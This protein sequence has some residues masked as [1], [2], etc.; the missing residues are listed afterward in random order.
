MGTVRG[1]G[2]QPRRQWCL[3]GVQR[4]SRT[5][6]LHPRTQIISR[7]GRKPLLA[8]AGDQG[9]RGGGEKSSSLWTREPS[10]EGGNQQ[11]T[12][13]NLFKAPLQLTGNLQCAGEVLPP[14]A[15]AFK[16]YAMCT[17][18]RITPGD[19]G[20]CMFRKVAE[21]TGELTAFKWFFFFLVWMFAIWFSY[22]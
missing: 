18:W 21:G 1:A 19:A 12:V 3:E 22:L 17:Q 10:Q 2:G 4:S 8:C 16:Q 7:N 5:I 15:P 20:L 9:E 14:E 13:A 6:C 11:T